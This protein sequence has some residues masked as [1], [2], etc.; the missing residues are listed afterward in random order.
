MADKVKIIDMREYPSSE[1]VR[2]GKFDKIVTYQVD[3]FHTYLITLPKEGFSED[4]LKEAIRK[5]M[6]ERGL[7]IGKELEL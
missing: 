1:P 2:A 5:D 3:A 6:K 4:K 7:W